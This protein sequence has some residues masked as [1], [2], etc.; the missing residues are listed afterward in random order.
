MQNRNGVV[1]AAGNSG[2]TSQVQL[3][4]GA[5]R[6][7]MTTLAV[8]FGIGIAFAPNYA[9][10]AACTTTLD[11][12]G[13]SPTFGQT[14]RHCTGPLSETGSTADSLTLD[15]ATG[16]DGYVLNGTGNPTG[17]DDGLFTNISSSTGSALTVNTANKI[18]STFT[19]AAN[20]DGDYSTTANGAAAVAFNAGNG[21]DTF[22]NS[23]FSATSSTGRGL[24]LISTGASGVGINATFEGSAIGGTTGLYAEAKSGTLSVTPTNTAVLSGSNEALRVVSKGAQ[25]SVTS[26]A[27]L[28][29]DMVAEVAGD[30]GGA[31]TGVL[32]YQANA[33]EDANTDIELNGGSIN[34]TG[35]GIV[36]QTDGTGS[37]NITATKA[38]GTAITAGASGILATS[39]N[40]G[41]ITIDTGANV[42]AAGGVGIAAANSTAGAN[43]GT[44]G[45]TVDAGTTVNATKAGFS[46]IATN[47]GVS[48]GESA[49]T[50]AGT[51]KAVT[52]GVTQTSNSGTNRVTIS[53]TGQIDPLIGIDQSTVNGANI[54]DN[55]GIVLGDNIGVRQ[56]A[57]GSGT[58]SIDNKAGASITGTA[59][60]AVIM[61]ATSGLQTVSNAG[62][63]EGTNGQGVVITSTSGHQSVANTGT[64]T[65]ATGAVR[66]TSTTGALDFGGAGG[67]VTGGN[68]G[69]VMES[70]GGAITVNGSNN[71]IGTAGKGVSL[72]QTGNTAATITLKT[73]GGDISGGTGGI[74][75]TTDGT[76]AIVLQPGG[77]VTASAGDAINASNTRAT[78]GG[79][80]IQV[81]VAAGTTV[82]GSDDGISTDTGL[83]LG[84]TAINVDG[85]V[86][87]TAGYGV[88]AVS[89]TVSNSVNT[90][91]NIHQ[92]AASTIT[93]GAGGVRVEALG[94]SSGP[95]VINAGGTVRSAV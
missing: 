44:I 26:T 78:T 64:I 86:T 1:G 10:A 29:G 73:T 16:T 58:N 90:G 84:G 17:I 80:S 33:A 42:T 61:T 19:G 39:T 55:S 25:I 62:D 71:I 37:V 50:I 6:T 92:A 54:V 28:D 18:I 45:I 82:S 38:G 95:V 21:I 9:L 14:I 3:R 52:T 13:G 24:S 31:G 11:T 59:Q 75:A 76:G 5:S 81:D 57:T 56:V 4:S 53:A 69:L 47:L 32:F 87:G 85:N 83:A 89:N 43:A 66:M 63:I 2:R 7:V 67:T 68:N 91:I 51:V 40:G 22:F 23:S 30:I 72:T 12:V 41:A 15:G 46:G 27:T 34:V 77:D 93:G 36:T 88:V 8:S 60:Q 79:G 48:T 49:V 65:A 70:A 35:T 20:M 74:V 94:T